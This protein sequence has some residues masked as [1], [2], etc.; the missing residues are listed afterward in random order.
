[1]SERHA[2]SVPAVLVGALTGGAASVLGAR[3]SSSRRLDLGALELAFIAGGYPAMAFHETSGKAM[4]I[5]FAVC[6][7]FMGLA[8]TGLERRSRTAIACGLVGH[9]GWDAVHHL[10]PTG[11]KPPR[12]FPAFCMVADLALAAQFL[13]SS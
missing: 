12:W 6:G 11:A 1:M 5:E 3:L 13:R 2:A 9:A 4:A 7:V 8:L 10:T